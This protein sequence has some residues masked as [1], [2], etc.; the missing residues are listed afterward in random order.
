MA[1]SLHHLFQIVTREL[2]SDGNCTDDLA[3][4]LKEKHGNAVT[5]NVLWCVSKP[6]HNL[7]DNSEGTEEGDGPKLPSHS[8]H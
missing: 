8:K 1:R 6:L 4:L 3:A 2:L 7:L 5:E